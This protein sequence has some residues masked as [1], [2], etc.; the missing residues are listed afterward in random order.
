MA[1]T[2][3]TRNVNLETPDSG[4][5]LE[6][7]VDVFDRQVEEVTPQIVDDMSKIPYS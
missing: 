3:I 7:L 4:G 6:S 2:T 1:V 5:S